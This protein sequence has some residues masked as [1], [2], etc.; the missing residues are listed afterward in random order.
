[1]NNNFKIAITKKYHN[2]FLYQK[3]QE[4]EYTQQQM[5]DYLQI[6]KATYVLFERMRKYPSKS[7]AEKISNKLGVDIQTIFPQ[8]IANDLFCKRDERPRIYELKQVQL[9]SP[10]VLKLTSGIEDTEEKI[11]DEFAHN[12]IMKKLDTLSIREKKIVEMFFGLKTGKSMSLLE[13]SKE[14]NVTRE[15][16]RQILLRAIR[17]LKHPS[18]AKDLYQLI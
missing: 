8:W 1:L 13:V 4:L 17:K 9:T 10:E 3:R 14:F 12:I 5:A 15:R 18:R 7:F 16:I 11:D 2:G 6:G